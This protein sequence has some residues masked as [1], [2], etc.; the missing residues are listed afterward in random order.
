[1]YDAARDLQFEKAA[2]IRDQI[3]LLKQRLLM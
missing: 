2:S 1:M 3:S